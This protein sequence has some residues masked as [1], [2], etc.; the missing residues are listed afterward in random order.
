VR[1]PNSALEGGKQPTPKLLLLG[2]WTLPGLQTQGLKE[3]SESWI[4]R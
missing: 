3:M 4:C 1:D 2:P